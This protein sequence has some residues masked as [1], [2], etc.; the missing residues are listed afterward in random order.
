MHEI[1][2]W[3]IECAL[4]LFGALRITEEKRI[5]YADTA[6]GARRPFYEPIDC[7]ERSAG[8]RHGP[9]ATLGHG[10]CGFHWHAVEASPKGL[11]PFTPIRR[12]EQTDIQDLLLDKRTFI[13][14]PNFINIGDHWGQCLSQAGKPQEN[15]PICSY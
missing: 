10:R 2:G 14:S 4:W 15:V 6:P 9:V 11:C 13:L 8:W 1:E 12:V 7:I 3:T 5:M